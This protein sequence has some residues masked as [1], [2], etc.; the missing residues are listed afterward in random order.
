[1]S[2]LSGIY[3]TLLGKECHKLAKFPNKIKKN[4]A[5]WIKCCILSVLT[6]C[7]KVNL[8]RTHGRGGDG[9]ICHRRV[10]LLPLV[11]DAGFCLHQRLSHAFQFC[12]KQD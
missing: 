7:H 11:A 5:L 8:G 2:G 1:M 6:L 4:A 3:K 12:G 10:L 9:Q